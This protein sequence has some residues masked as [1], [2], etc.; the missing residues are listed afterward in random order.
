[1]ANPDSHDSNASCDCGM[2][3]TNLGKSN[4]S[5]SRLANS[6]MHVV[7]YFTPQSR[8]HGRNSPW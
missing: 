4:G 1:M 3:S 2:V 5:L 7:A 6:G 8:N